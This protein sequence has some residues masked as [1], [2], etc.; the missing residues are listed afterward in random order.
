MKSLYIFSFGTVSVKM[1]QQKRKKEL[2]N[3]TKNNRTTFE[4]FH[5]CAGNASQTQNCILNMSIMYERRM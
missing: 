2:K 1:T 5:F 4:S 3:E